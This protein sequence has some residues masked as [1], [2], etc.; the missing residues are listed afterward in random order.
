MGQIERFDPEHKPLYKVQYIIWKS[1]SLRVQL[2][3]DIVNLHIKGAL[4]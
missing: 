4:E 3:C 1:Q 2:T